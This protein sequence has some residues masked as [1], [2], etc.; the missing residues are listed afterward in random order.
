MSA[1]AIAT[2]TTAELAQRVNDDVGLHLWNVLTDDYFTG[3][4]IPGSRRVPVDRL[5]DALRRSSLAKDA[6]IVVYCIGPACPQSRQAA[7]KL[8][9]FGYTRV[10][11]YEGGLQEWTQAGFGVVGTG[12]AR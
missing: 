4:L 7:E 10:D 6:A 12:A 8:V 9:A 3:E 1:A 5:G 11:V 2:I